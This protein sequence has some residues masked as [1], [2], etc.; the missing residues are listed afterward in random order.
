MVLPFAS[1][2]ALVGEGLALLFAEVLVKYWKTI[3]FEGVTWMIL[4][5][6]ESV[7]KVSPLARYGL[8]RPRS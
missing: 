2:T 7:I 4:L 5:C 3:C 6:P 1:L 8:Q